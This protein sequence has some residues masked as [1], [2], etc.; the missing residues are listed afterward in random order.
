M[1]ESTHSRK[2]E[3]RV[4]FET[5]EDILVYIQKKNP[6]IIPFDYEGRQHIKLQDLYMAVC[7]VKRKTANTRI[8]DL[9]KKCGEL[10]KDLVKRVKQG[11]EFACF[12]LY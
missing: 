2:M 7:D 10:S 11:S 3:D 5:T 4:V 8:G 9:G 6:E 12:F 1:V